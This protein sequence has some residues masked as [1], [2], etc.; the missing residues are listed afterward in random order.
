MSDEKIINFKD[1]KDKVRP[2]DVDKFEKHMF[3]TFEKMSSGEMSMFE[4]TNSLS[5]YL[6][7]NNIEPDKFVEIEKSLL[8]RYGFDKDSFDKF[9][10]ETENN[11]DS[12]KNV[13]VVEGMSADTISKRLTFYE[14]Y[15]E[16]LKET[17][18]LEMNF[19]NEKNDVRFIFDQNKI[20]MISDK[21]IDLSDQEL[22]KIITFYKYATEGS[23]EVIMCEATNKYEYH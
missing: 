2:S 19:K 20:T 16:Q 8:E 13:K 5:K 23:L 21:K 18:C 4:F 12:L 1:L 17:K 3:E 6:A 9:K 22:N 11:K 7:D 10:A 15:S 14:F